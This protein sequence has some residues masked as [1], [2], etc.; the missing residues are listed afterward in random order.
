MADRILLWS[1]LILGFCFLGETLITVSISV[2]VIGLLI[3]SLS[4]WFRLG[5]LNFS[6]NL[7]IS[8]RL[9]IFIAIV[10]H[11]TLLQ[12]FVLHCL[13][14]L[15]FFT[16]NFVDLILLSL[17]LISLGKR[18]VNFVYLLKAPAFSFINLY[19]CFFHFFFIYICSGLYDIF[20]STNFGFFFLLLLLLL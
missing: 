2:L 5:R 6:K 3:I 11:N 10:I 1:H 17:F 9:C 18:F 8:C 16:C 4:S 14:N 15:S 20:P 13:C 12:A 7:S 19:Y